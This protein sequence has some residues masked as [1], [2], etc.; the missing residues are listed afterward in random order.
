MRTTERA[1]DLGEVFTPPTI[2]SDMLGLLGDSVQNATL[3][4]L[5]PSCGN[6]N[7]LVEILTIRLREIQRKVQNEKLQGIAFIQCVTQIY[8]IDIDANNVLE[9]R[10]RLTQVF[11]SFLERFTSDHREALVQSAKGVFESNITQGDSL[12]NPDSILLTEYALLDSENFQ[13]TP[14][15]LQEQQRDL[16]FI[17]PAGLENRH[18]LELHK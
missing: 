1:Q 9:C 2:V 18:Y 7:F 13:R 4:I 14:F 3:S 8:G 16:F 17:E 6:G 12:N 10:N 5:E 11:T 15:F